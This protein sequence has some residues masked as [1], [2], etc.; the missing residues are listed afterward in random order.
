MEAALLVVGLS[1]ICA[2]LATLLYEFLSSRVVHPLI[3]AVMSRYSAAYVRRF[4]V[5]HF[6]QNVG[7]VREQADLP[8]S[9]Y[10]ILIQGNAELMGYGGFFLGS[11]LKTLPTDKVSQQTCIAVGVL[12]GA[13]K[14][15]LRHRTKV[16]QRHILWDSEF[17]LIAAEV[18]RQRSK[19]VRL[20]PKRRIWMNRRRVMQIQSIDGLAHGVL[21]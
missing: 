14:A 9:F 18:A 6:E 16:R 5:E 17:G 3:D 20:E 10:D 13:T 11:Y 15:L 8:E 2:V 1:F 7:L 21:G 4:T 19:A 12:P